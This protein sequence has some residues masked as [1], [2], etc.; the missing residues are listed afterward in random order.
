M[1]QGRF[2]S[3]NTGRESGLLWGREDG[4][5]SVKS[6]SGFQDSALLATLIPVELGLGDWISCSTWCLSYVS[7]FPA[8][9]L[10]AG[11]QRPRL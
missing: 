7:F 10:R 11:L 3:S 6:Y 9:L 4:D 1:D 2:L 5:I 8:P